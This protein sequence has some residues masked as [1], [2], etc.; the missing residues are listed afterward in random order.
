ML[1]VSPLTT[2]A[3][4][5]MTAKVTRYCESETAKV[6]R[7][8]TKKKSKAATLRTNASTDGPR[9]VRVETA[10]TLSRYTM[11]MFGQL[12]VRD[13]Q[14]GDRRR[15]RDHGDAPART[16]PG[17]SAAGGIGA[18]RRGFAAGSPLMTWMSISPLPRTSASTIEPRSSR[19]QTRALRLADHDLA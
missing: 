6:K 12:E 14:P 5:S 16:P 3:T 18:P 4:I 17:P 10:T 9:P 11:T 13:H 7:G 2:R 19:F 15:R 8:G 1:T